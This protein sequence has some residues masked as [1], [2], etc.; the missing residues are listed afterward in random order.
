MTKTYELTPVDGRKSFYGKC[1][2]VQYPSKEVLFSY[3]TRI[4]TRKNDGTLIRHW[5]GW[6]MTTGRHIKAFCGIE[7]KEFE[8][9]EVAEG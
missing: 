6:S 2:V 5:D 4:L 9:M 8:S 7:K 3:N 1:Y